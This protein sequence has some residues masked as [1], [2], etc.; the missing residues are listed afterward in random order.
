MID[1]YFAEEPA[2]EVL[3]E[4]LDA[5]GRLIRSFSSEKLAQK[6]EDQDLSALKEELKRIG[7]PRLKKSPGM[8]RFFWDLRHAGAWHPETNRAGRGG[9]LIAT[10]AYQAKLIVANWTHK[11]R[12]R[13]QMDPRVEE[14]GVSQS[15][16]VA[17]QSL[18][19]QIRD[20]L[21]LARMAAERI[22][23]AREPQKLNRKKDE[24]LAAIYSKLVTAKIIY[25]QPMLIDQLQYLFSMLNRADQKPGRDAYLRLDDLNKELSGY[26]SEIDEILGDN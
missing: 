15:D 6:L 9:P 11:E 7:G 26:I 13:L 19:L 2:G 14:D 23:K 16:L 24:R 3:L 4:I 21:S 17:Q 20:T 8:H 1:Y 22:R 25:P 5:N 10:G 12:F 18:S